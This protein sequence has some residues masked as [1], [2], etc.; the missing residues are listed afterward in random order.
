[1]NCDI[2]FCR[3]RAYQ[4][5]KTSTKERE[6]TNDENL[7]LSSNGKNHKAYRGIVKLGEY[8]C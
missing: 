3:R 2:M 5:G 4:E 6:R 7:L 8:G 1:M